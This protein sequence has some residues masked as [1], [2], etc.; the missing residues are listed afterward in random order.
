MG[1]IGWFARNKV[2]ANLIAVLAVVGGAVSIWTVKQEVFPEFS[3]N[4]ISVSVPYLGAAPEE[5]EEGVCLR[6]EE[7]IQVLLGLT[8]VLA[9]QSAEVDTV[10][11]PS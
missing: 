3:L 2:A 10:E 6:V 4:L 11:R 8:D 9:D 1:T 7:A 5:V